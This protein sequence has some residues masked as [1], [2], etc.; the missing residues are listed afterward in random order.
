MLDSIRDGRVEGV[1]DKSV[2]PEVL[3]AIKE[4]DVLWLNAG[5]VHSDRNL[6]CACA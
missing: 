5:S 4:L 6:T 3:A 2:A 1:L